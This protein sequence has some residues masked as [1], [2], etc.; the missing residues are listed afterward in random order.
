MQ[1]SILYMMI[2]C[3]CL[4]I[5]NETLQITMYTSSHLSA[6][7]DMFTLHAVSENGCSLLSQTERS[8]LPPQAPFDTLHSI[9]SYCQ[10]SNNGNAVIDRP[11]IVVWVLHF[12]CDLFALAQ[13]YN[14]FIFDLLLPLFTKF[15]SIQVCHCNASARFDAGEFKVFIKVWKLLNCYVLL[16]FPRL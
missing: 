8:A 16:F 3:H 5:K 15:A 13:Q 10:T 2:Q 11:R 14:G 1:Y 6:M 7:F 9:I 4:Q 12:V